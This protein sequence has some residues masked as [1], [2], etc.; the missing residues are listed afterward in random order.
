MDERVSELSRR[1]AASPGDE[2]AARE[3][4]R[5]LDLRL[6]LQY[7]PGH[8]GLPGNEAADAEAE[9]AAQGVQADPADATGVD[10]ASAR[11]AAAVTSSAP[12]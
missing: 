8:C 3:L 7:V 11:A 12:R 10:R 9:A 1:V 2:G 6:L 4:E 5:A